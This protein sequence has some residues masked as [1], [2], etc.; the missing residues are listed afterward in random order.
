MIAA[1]DLF[2][3]YS[4]NYEDSKA[5]VLLKTEFLKAAEGIVSDY[6]GFQ[7]EEKEYRDVLLD[8]TGTGVL[9]LPARNITK[10]ISLSFK[11]EPQSEDSFFLADDRIEYKE[12]YTFHK[13]MYKY[14]NISFVAGWK[15]ESI[16]S[17]IR[18]AVLRI[19]TLMLQETG[20]NIGLTGKSFADNSHTFVSYSNYRK[21]LEPLAP[22]RIRR[23]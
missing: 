15:S 8:G 1:I 21:Y 22:L 11:D 4:G 9:Y 14:I 17:V 13:R 3:A 5:A 20:G 7:P 12:L 18:L 23:F 6:L 16:P 2:N 10:L 19:A